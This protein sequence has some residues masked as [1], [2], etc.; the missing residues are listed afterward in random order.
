[1]K[2]A[3]YI[4]NGLESGVARQALL[5]KAVEEALRLRPD[6]LCSSKAV[7]LLCKWTIQSGDKTS[8][9]T[10]AST[11]KQIDPKLLQPVVE[12]FSQH[13]TGM[14]ASDER[15][16]VI[17]SIAKRRCEWLNDQLQALGKPFSWEMPD[18]YFPD[19]AKVQAFLRGP[20]AS[21]KT[22]GVR[23]FNGVRHARNYANKWMRGQQINASYTLEP[24]GRGQSAYV[25]IKKTR[26]W[27]SEHQKKLLEYKTEFN[28]LSTRFEDASA[29]I[30]SKRARYE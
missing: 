19:N 24:D 25:T 15:F 28:L 26:A 14:D 9:D 29:G 5:E 10:V 2:V 1:M 30:S 6:K 18:A 13:A 16:A 8:F 7:D 27:F 20:D 11:F 22:V 17:V 23:Q 4:V 21:M 12:A 3:L